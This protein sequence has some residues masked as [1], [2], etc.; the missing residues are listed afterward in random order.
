MNVIRSKEHDNYSTKV[1]K[2]AL[3]AKDNKGKILKN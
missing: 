2:I 1:N 3:S